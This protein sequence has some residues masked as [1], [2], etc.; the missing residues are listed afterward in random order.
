MVLLHWP[1]PDHLGIGRKSR[2]SLHPV[3]ECFEAAFSH[4]AV[5]FKFGRCGDASD[6]LGIQRDL[7]VENL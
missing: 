6:Q 2:Q 5:P 1:P 4:G 7:G 3:R